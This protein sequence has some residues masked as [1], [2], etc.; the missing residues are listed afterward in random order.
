MLH[1]DPIRLQLGRTLPFGL[2]ARRSYTAT[3]SKCIDTRRKSSARSLSVY[4]DDDG[5]IRYKCHH[6]GC[7]WETW[8]RVPDPAPDE[9][10]RTSV[11]NAIMPIPLD[12]NIPMDYNG[13]DLYWYKDLEGRHMFANRRINLPTGKIYVPFIY[14]EEGFTTGKAAKWPTDF[15]GLYGAETIKN[16]SKVV[17]VEGEKAAEAAKKIFRSQAVVSWRGGAKNIASADW[18][19]LQDMHTA[20]LWPDNDDA[21]KQVMRQ[22]AGL[23]PCSKILIASV[24]HLPAGADLADNLS[25]EDIKTA[26]AN[27]EDR[28][29]KETGVFTLD[30]IEKQ[31]TETG[32]S[33][34]SGFEVFDAHTKL[35]GS[36]LVVIEGRTKHGKSALAVALTSS[37]LH[38]GLETNISFYNYEMTAAKVFLRYLKSLNPSADL[39]NYKTLPEYSEVAGWISSGRLKIFDQ[40]AQKGIGEIVLAASRPNMRGGI[41]I[42]DYLQII[43]MSSNYGRSRQ[44]IIKE[45]LDE[46]RVVAHKNRVLVLVLSQ[47]TPD[48]TNPA[49]DSPRE[50]KDIHYSADLVLRVWNK[51]VGEA[52][53]SYANVTGN[54]IIHT[55]LN[56]DGESNVRFE[57][58]LVNGSRLAVKKRIREAK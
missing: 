26:V 36:G 11:S 38:K 23:L 7:E 3:C 10:D 1:R 45:M 42:L 18:S 46:L 58:S 35:P 9:I 51:A 12:V 29:Y 14:T 49:N 54:Y 53:P 21:G 19:L 47:L 24:D 44:L 15:K 41:L 40:S 52:N 8:Q 55:Y 28:S 13:D 50:A 39:T 2:E 37:M 22:I 30:D 34:Q 4:R 57:G 20:L 48:Y 32:S 5:F 27:A 16:A 6:P 31:L 56:R 43:P 33:R 17:I 25:A